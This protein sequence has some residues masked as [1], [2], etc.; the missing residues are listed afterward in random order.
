MMVCRRLQIDPCILS[1]TKLMS[2]W[3]NDLNIIPAT[4]NFLEKVGG[5]LEEI[6]IGNC[7]LNITPVAQTLISTIN[8]WDLLK[9]R[10]FCKAKDTVHDS[11]QTGKRF[12]PILDLTKG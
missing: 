4:L 2:K 5:T 6:G 7:F 10:S 11:P 3:I 9:L 8:K 1:C 12:L